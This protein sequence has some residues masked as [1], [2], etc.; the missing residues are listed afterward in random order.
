MCRVAA[1]AVEVPQGV[2][3]ASNT[4]TWN[5]VLVRYPTGYYLTVAS[6][7]SYARNN[8]RDCRK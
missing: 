4:R 5:L 1:S 6:G 7:G 3:G 8:G 2:G